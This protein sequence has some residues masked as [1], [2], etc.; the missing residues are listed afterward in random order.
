M[1]GRARPPDAASSSTDA[2][3]LAEHTEP[4]EMYWL[5][6]LG[7]DN[8]YEVYDRETKEPVGEIH[9]WY[10]KRAVNF[11]T[12]NPTWKLKCSRHGGLCQKLLPERQRSTESLIHAGALWLVKDGNACLPGADYAR[13]HKALSIALDLQ[14]L[15]VLAMRWPGTGL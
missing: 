12:K 8:G 14:E 10:S 7:T 9:P 4:V 6:S 2:A 1:Q 11:F 3:V 15:H 5:H 13:M